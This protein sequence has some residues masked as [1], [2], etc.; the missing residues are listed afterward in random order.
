MPRNKIIASNGCPWNSIRQTFT[1]TC[2]TI[3]VFSQID[4]Q[5]SL[6][7]MRPHMRMSHFHLHTFWLNWTW[8]A[9]PKSWLA[10]F[11]LSHIYPNKPYFCISLWTGCS[12]YSANSSNRS[13]W[14]SIS[15][16]S[17]TLR[18]VIRVFKKPNK[19]QSFLL[20]ILRATSCSIF[21]VV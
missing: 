19:L 15:E 21:F 2:R 3:S 9:S 14:N 16:I 4:P 8:L 7:Y 20:L 11:T 13:C 10:R 18:F 1:V 6:V 12:T 5:Q 17:A